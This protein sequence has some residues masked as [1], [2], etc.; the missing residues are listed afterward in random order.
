MKNKTIAALAVL[1]IGLSVNFAAP[2]KATEE[3]SEQETVQKQEEIQSKFS[4]NEYTLLDAEG[5]ELES[6]QKKEPFTLVLTATD[7]AVSTQDALQEK[8]LDKINQSISSLNIERLTDDFSGGEDIQ[9]ILLSQGVQ[10]LKVKI[11]FK[12]V[13]YRG[14]GD[15]FRFRIGYKALNIGYSDETIKIQECT[16]TAEEEKN[17]EKPGDDL[18]QDPVIEGGSA[19]GGYYSGGTGDFSSE[20]VKTAAPNLIVKK[21]SWGKK[22]VVSGKEF[23]LTLTFYNTSKTLSTEN[24]VVSLETEEGLSIA[25]GSNTF[26]FENL[27]PQASQTIKVKM[28]ALSM[29]KNGSPGIAVNFRYD[30][31]E[32]GERTNQQTSEKISIPVYLK[33]RFEIT[34]PTLPEMVSA[35]S[36]CVVSFPY[37]N[38]GKSTLSN[39]SVKV[40]GDIPALQPVQ[41]LGNFEPGKSGTID[42]ILTPQNPGLQKGEITISYENASEEEVDKKFPVEL[43]VE[44]AVVPE[45]MEEPLV[46]ENQEPGFPWGWLIGVA[47]II[48][49]SLILFKKHKKK[50]KIRDEQDEEYDF[51]EE[52]NRK[53]D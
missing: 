16:N 46:Q 13:S 49:G 41:N 45:S 50:K 33:D 7:T 32:D 38:K 42:V 26:Y 36:E 3:N 40:T 51:N 15:T 4:V 27:A 18:Q 35:G 48:G 52:I 10:P 11:I 14:K 24:I 53:E 8:D 31:V 5:K 44:E 23:T 43:N 21:Y 20:K 1:S 30:F 22:D 39:V 12:N 29:E 47:A 25:E 19:G 17:E 6:I 34:D 37:V 9:V 28:K 2:L